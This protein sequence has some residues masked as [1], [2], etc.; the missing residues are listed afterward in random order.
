MALRGPGE[1]GIPTG[2]QWSKL[3]NRSVREFRKDEMITWAAAGSYYA[4]FSLFPILILFVS[5]L[6]LFISTPQVE[7]RIVSQISEQV[8]GITGFLRDAIDRAIKSGGSLQVSALSRC[9]GRPRTSS[10]SPV[11][12]FPGRLT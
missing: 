6:T 5:V 11:K 4:V 8:P 1:Y 12:R 9:S 3:A 10:I 2:K 7:Q